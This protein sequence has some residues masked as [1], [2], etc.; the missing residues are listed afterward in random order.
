MVNNESLS[1]S[2]Q[3]NI[4]MDSAA[5]NYAGYQAQTF[6]KANEER[7]DDMVKVEQAI[8]D[9]GGIY[10]RLAL[11]IHEQEEMVQR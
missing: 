8:V 4:D 3:V 11:M 7:E 10:E 1:N 9:I 6:M 2:G 5:T